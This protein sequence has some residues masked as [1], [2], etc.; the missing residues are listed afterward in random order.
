MATSFKPPYKIVIRS[1]GNELELMPGQS[2]NGM[3]YYKYTKSETKLGIVLPLR[4]DQ[5]IQLIKTQTQ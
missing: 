2:K 3:Y 4:E 5:L 1:D